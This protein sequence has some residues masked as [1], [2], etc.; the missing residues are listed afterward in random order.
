MKIPSRL[1]I[2]TESCHPGSFWLLRLG[3]KLC[4]R[5][6]HHTVYLDLHSQCVFPV[7][8]LELAVRRRRHKRPRDHGT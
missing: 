8:L 7:D 4:T 1:K 6:E 5:V 3:A 2:R